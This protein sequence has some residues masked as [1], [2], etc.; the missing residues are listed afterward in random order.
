MRGGILLF[1]GALTLGFPGLL[2]PVMA[3][4]EAAQLPTSLAEPQD[5]HAVAEFMD[6]SWPHEGIFGT[7]DRAALQRGFQV[8]KEVC[9]AC[10]GAKYLAFR[11]LTDLGYDEEEI[12]AIAAGYTMTDGPNDEGEMFERPAIPS[13]RFPSPFPNEQAAAAANGG[14]APPDLSLI[15]KARVD[16]EDYLYSLLNGY[17]PP[18]PGVEVPEGG[19]YNKY[20]PGHVIAMPPPLTA[21]AVTYGDGTSATV[22]QMAA[23]VTQFLTWAAEPKLE[24]RKRTGIKAMLF[25]IVLTGLLYAWKR[26]IW[27]DVAH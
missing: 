21:D 3:A 6:L 16:G 15:V 25:L 1:A 18:P 22:Q 17:E 9:A 19:H 2:L 12:K 5:T 10:H 27:A 23:D 11:N 7:F 26:K 14:K 8:Y 20:F 4:E 13:D 24:E